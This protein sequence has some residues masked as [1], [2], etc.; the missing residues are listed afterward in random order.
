MRKILILAAIAAIMGNQSASAD[1]VSH[2]AF[3]G[4]A[5]NGI[6][7]QAAGTENGAITYS[8]GKFGDAAF[9]TSGTDNVDT[10]ST[11]LGGIGTGD[12]SVSVWAMFNGNISGD[13]AFLGNKDW[14][15]GSNPGL[16][17]AVKGG[18]NLDV[19]TFGNERVDFQDG[20]T[21]DLTDSNWHNIILVR[22]GNE[23]RYYFDGTAEDSPKAITAGADFTGLNFFVGDDGT[24]AYNNAGN[25][26]ANDF[27]IDDL[28]V[29][30][31]ALT[32]AEIAQL[33]NAS[34]SSLSGVPEPSSLMVLGLMGGVGLLRRKRR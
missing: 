6:A 19:N 21:S 2:F 23:L 29:F 17:Y 25:N 1:V 24:G 9:I 3:D 10:N 8:A 27:G 13:P 33:Q 32:T 34:A 5:T 18:G 12:F 30:D 14:A 31:S 28:A 16:L 15:S 7:G 22:E 11:T 4:N 26:W 20:D